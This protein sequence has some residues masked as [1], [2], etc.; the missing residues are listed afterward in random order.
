MRYPESSP[1]R[2]RWVEPVHSYC[3]FDGRKAYNMDP[4]QLS[5]DER[6]VGGCVYCGREPDTSDHVP[7]KA[8]LDNPLPDNLPVVDA[9]TACN[10]GFS[11]DEEYLTCFLEAVQRGSTVAGS[12]IREKV[13]RTLTHNPKL[14]ARIEAA[15][16]EDSSANWCGFRNQIVCEM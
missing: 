10:Q 4:R 3:W 14:A 2:W 16:T 8:L 11:T 15:K 6:L 1:T 9:C 7:S 5:A 12:L 13:Q